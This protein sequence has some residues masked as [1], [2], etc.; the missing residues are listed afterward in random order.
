MCSLSLSSQCFTSCGCHDHRVSGENVRVWVKCFPSHGLALWAKELT[1]RST[2]HLV[3]LKTDDTL[4]PPSWLVS[5][6]YD[7]NL[8]VKSRIFSCQTACMA[9]SWRP[10]L[11]QW[12]MCWK[13]MLL[14]ADT[15]ISFSSKISP[16]EVK[17]NSLFSL[18]PCLPFL[19][20]VCCQKSLDY[21]GYLYLFLFLNKICWRHLDIMASCKI[22]G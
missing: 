12:P 14:V 8:R 13:L 5:W 16:F 20:P 15:W 9:H 2:V 4:G 21:L 10:V 17:E 22:S 7:T 6:W 18:P 11:K 1:F 19:F 3:F